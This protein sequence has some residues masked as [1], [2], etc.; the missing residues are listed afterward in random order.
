MLILLLFV[1]V[2]FVYKVEDTNQFSIAIFMLLDETRVSGTNFYVL[3]L[4]INAKHK[5]HIIKY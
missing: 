3:N 1:T 2:E 5:M 4:N